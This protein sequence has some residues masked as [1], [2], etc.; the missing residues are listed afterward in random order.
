MLFLGRSTEGRTEDE[1]VPLAL[2]IEGE[3]TRTGM[4]GDSA[5]GEAIVAMVALDQQRREC[6][7]EK[8][9]V[10]RRYMSG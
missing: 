3:V 10:A 1:G 4:A 7:G 6:Q 2:V 5:R 8:L 9:I